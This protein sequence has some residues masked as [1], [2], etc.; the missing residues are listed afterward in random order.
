MRLKHHGVSGC[1]TQLNYHLA[2]FIKSRRAKKD[3]CKASENSNQTLCCSL[4]YEVHAK[5]TIAVDADASVQLVILIEVVHRH[6]SN[7]GSLLPVA[8]SRFKS[9][10]IIRPYPRITNITVVVW[11]GLFVNTFALV[12]SWP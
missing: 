9:R 7:P 4:N 12:Y 2:K 6:I 11:M 5:I 10:V 1:L 8:W 3:Y